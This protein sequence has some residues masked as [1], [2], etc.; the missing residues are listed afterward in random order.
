MPGVCK[1]H[2]ARVRGR[3]DARVRTLNVRTWARGLPAYVRARRACVGAH[4]LVRERDCL[5]LRVHERAPVR[6]RVHVRACVCV[7]GERLTSAAETIAATTCRLHSQY[8]PG[9]PG[10]GKGTLGI[11]LFRQS[12]LCKREI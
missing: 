11:W 1:V 6:M 10:F 2:G 3:A 8:L 5:R 12:R 7:R 9:G 4:V